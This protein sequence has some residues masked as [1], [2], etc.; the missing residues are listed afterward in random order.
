MRIRIRPPHTSEDPP[1]SQEPSRD[2]C[3][4]LTTF[5]SNTTLGDFLLSACPQFSFPEQVTIDNRPYQLTDCLEEL[6]LYDGSLISTETASPSLDLRDWIVRVSGGVNAGKAINIKEGETLS[7]GRADDADIHSD[8]LATSWFHGA[9]RILDS[10]AYVYDNDSS[11]GTFFN[12]EKVSEKGLYIPDSGGMIVAGGLV[13]TI[14]KGL[15]ES[16]AAL[17][18]TKIGHKIPFNRPPRR[19][20]PPL[21]K[22]LTPPKRAAASDKVR[23]SW[24]AIV[25]PLLM[26]A[27]LVLRPGG[28]PWYALTALLSPIMAIGTYFENKRRSKKD[29]KEKGAEYEQ[30]LEVF[31]EDVNA[32]QQAMRKRINRMTLD[33][34]LASIRAKTPT[35]GLWERRT[36]MSDCLTLSVGVGHIDWDVPLKNKDGKLEEEISAVVEE[37]K[38]SDVPVNVDLAAGEVLGICGERETALGLMRSLLTQ[39]TVGMGP[40]DM[41]VGI[42]ADKH[43]HEDWQW[44]G[45]L[46]HTRVPGSTN[47]SRYISSDY[48]Q[49]QEI[50]DG[51]DNSIDSFITDLFLLVIDS[52]SLLEGRDAPARRLAGYGRRAT[53]RDARMRVPALIYAPTSEQLPSSCTWVLH[54]QEDGQLRLDKPEERLK[55]KNIIPTTIT[56]SKAETI[57]A[58]TARFD[59]PE[60][61]SLST[62]LPSLVPLLSVLGIHGKPTEQNIL[63]LWN[64]P[65][66]MSTPIGVTEHGTYSL[67]I[68]ANGP[69]GLVGGTTG[70]GKSEFLRSLVAGLAAR[71]TPEELTFI[72]VDFKGGAAFASCD[73]LPHTIGTLSN[74]DPQLALRAVKALEAE[75]R[76]RQ[77]LFA[78]TG[79]D[80]DNIDA[81]RKTN[82]E[83]PLP[84]LL[85]VVDEFAQ[86]AHEYPDVLKSLVS[87]AAVG[88]TLGVHMILATQRPA[89][90]VNQDILA[91]TNLR[92]ALRVQSRDD[93]SSVIGTPQA[94][95]I[96]SSERGRAYIRLG[97]TEISAIQ[98]AL[99]TASTTGENITELTIYPTSPEKPLTPPKTPLASKSDKTDLD[100]LIEAINHAHTSAGYSKPRPVWPE[101]LPEHLPLPLP[102]PSTPTLIHLGLSDDPD[103]QRQIPAS[104]D[105]G[106]GNILFL[107]IPGSGTS[108]A[109][110]TLALQAAHAYSPKELDIVTLD[111]LE[112]ALS[113]LRNLPHSIIY[114][115]K[116]S[117]G[118]EV[119][120]RTIRLL[121]RELKTRL[122]NPNGT[123]RTIIVLCDGFVTMIDDLGN[124]STFDQQALNLFYRL[125]SEGA[126][127]GIHIAASATRYQT[128]P[129]LIRDIT[130]QKWAFRFTDSSDYA[131]LGKLTRKDKPSDLPGRCALAT[132]GLQTHIATPKT[133]IEDSLNEITALYTD[134][135][136]KKPLTHT[137]PDA[138][139]ISSVNQ[140]TEFAKDYWTIPI[141]IT[142]TDLSPA[143]L[144]TWSGEHILISGPV[145]SGK[146][147]TLLALKEKITADAHKQNKKIHTYAVTGK[148]S[149][150]N[151]HSWDYHT[152]DPRDTPTITTLI[153]ANPTD[154]HLVFID[155][156][157]SL[158]DTGSTLSN[159]IAHTEEN[160]RLFVAV[161]ND[162][163]RKPS[164]W[165]A[166]IR[167]KRCGILLMPTNPTT[168]EDI[169]HVTLPKRLP[170]ALIPGRGFICSS[171]QATLAHIAM[172]TSP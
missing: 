100:L 162:E 26:A 88:R 144:E 12:G 71:C 126:S 36:H 10:K 40:A 114:A 20:L 94:S 4:A 159:L 171:G 121:A 154:M 54:I 8:S 166:P 120:N 107:G 80:I 9:I 132:T 72:L 98:T 66:T 104:W 106:Q 27:V 46:P 19:G 129:T 53:R 87:I 39:A 35:T 96:S 111:F 89:G 73:R 109:L 135:T 172:P 170:V 155:D 102:A 147:S 149:P 16:P 79:P 5:P 38:L 168:D 128:V 134:A 125:W 67:D 148:R 157:E 93:S 112:G 42:F 61:T 24:I 165:Y 146:S 76:Y 81:Y 44:A 123:Y 139:P 6:P 37:A 136:P 130:P 28:S 82:P 119:Q 158:D 60:T 47:E 142:E 3:V 68:V 1:H 150:L 51:L 59:D 110:T 58:S 97:E 30:E 131:G 92:V 2:V 63:E 62:S 85:F 137:L 153:K 57:A 127:V 163:G 117:G 48:H 95:S 118:L 31:L 164:A 17:S 169:L 45:W 78:Q 75:M 55:I 90:V 74:L 64:A 141:G 70:S 49:S 25:A 105:L 22:E 29:K 13:L 11:N 116:S 41:T 65:H 152:T 101:E 86:L 91:N 69:H 108:T 52:E 161:R 21:P 56:L 145:R 113:P 7:F 124:G 15:G 77:E 156:A 99:V 103:N 33:P 34:A 122:E 32:A 83:A 23:F 167:K 151:E 14:T 138:F 18:E 143:Q 160:I 133:S 140:N 115:S 50:L 84:R 43:Y